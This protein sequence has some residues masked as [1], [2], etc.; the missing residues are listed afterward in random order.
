MTVVYRQAG[1]TELSLDLFLAGAGD[2]PAMVF[3]H[4]L[5]AATDQFWPQARAFRAQG[6]VTASVDYRIGPAFP[7]PVAD[8]KAAVRWLRARS[9]EYGIDPKRVT[10]VGG[11]FGGH[12]AAMLAA[13][14]GMWEEGENLDQDSTVGAVILL[15]PGLDLA[16]AGPSVRPAVAEFVKA[17][18]GGTPEEAPST[19]RV[20]SAFTY[21][22]ATLPPTLL[23][24]GTDDQTVTYAQAVA[25]RD[26]LKAAGG[27]V[28][29]FTA[30]GAGHAF[31][32]HEPWLT[33]TLA[34][35]QDF[36]KTY[37]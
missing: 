19:Y 11:S 27:I 34:A 22:K 25:Y 23:L 14:P 35:M 7:G 26:A 31:F 8:A 4:G 3:F 28:E 18:L 12:L 36:A 24:H 2:H 17:Y 13:T 5:G 32:N 16:D 29:L 21:V 10:A 1:V 15:N 30:E 20:A 37:G 6:Y 9:R 33:R